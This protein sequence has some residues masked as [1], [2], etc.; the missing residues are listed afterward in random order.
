M[1]LTALRNYLLSQA[2]VSALVGDRIFPHII[3]QGVVMP[4]ADLRLLSPE[5]TN[6]MGG[7][8][9]HSQGQI[10]IDCYSDVEPDQAYAVAK[11]IRDC[12]M[13]DY[14]GTMGDFFVAGIDLDNDITL[15]TE[16]VEPGSANWRWVATLAVR[17]DYSDMS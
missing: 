3:D 13:I 2:S 4:A 12:G 9:K 7:W 10:V 5:P 15:D 11:A 1:I 8:S 6:H 14:R 16:N 17:I